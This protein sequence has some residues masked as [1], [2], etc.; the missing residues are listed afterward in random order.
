MTQDTARKTATMSSAVMEAAAVMQKIST[1]LELVTQQ[2]DQAVS[3]SA[4]ATHIV[5]AGTTAADILEKS[6]EEIGTVV[7]MISNIA[8]QTNMLALNAQIEASRAGE[9]GKGFAVVARYC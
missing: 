2:T 5:S 1:S 6:A 7:A 3:M 9:S 4:E 8:S